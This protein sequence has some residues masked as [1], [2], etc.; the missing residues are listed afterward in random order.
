MQEYKLYIDGRFCDAEGGR[1]AD[2][3]NPA[4]EEPWARVARASLK[5][6]ERA[7]AAARKAFDEG[8]W[9]R[10]SQAERAKILNQIAAGLDAKA[11]HIA[12]VETQ[13]SGGTIRKTGGD[14]M[15]GAAQLRYFAEMAEKVPLDGGDPGPAVSGAVEE[16]S[17]RASRSASAARSFRGTSRS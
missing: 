5:D 1:T 2:S 9:P 17:S 16:L 13:D 12:A 3:I 7:I 10:M 14:M 11:Q 4:T 8:P 15:L 6:T